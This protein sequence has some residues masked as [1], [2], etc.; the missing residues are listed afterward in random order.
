LHVIIQQ[1][2]IEPE[3]LTY[4]GTRT[5]QREGMTPWHWL[6]YKMMGLDRHA[7]ESAFGKDGLLQEGGVN[8]DA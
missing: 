7:V 3:F 8:A 6:R 4:L 2:R 1:A 5:V